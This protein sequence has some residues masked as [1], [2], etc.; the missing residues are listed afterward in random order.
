MSGVDKVQTNK[1]SINKETILRITLHLIEEKGG[2]KNVTLR[3]IAKKIECAHTNLY[4]YF[5]SLDELFWESLGEVLIIMMNYTDLGLKSN[6]NPEENIYLLLS[7]LIDFSMDHPGW[8]RLI[9][10][11][12]IGGTPSIEVI[13]ILHKPGEEFCAELIKAGNNISKEKANSISDILHCYLHGELCKWINKR[14]FI[15]SREEIKIKILS[16]LKYMY[17]SLIK[18]EFKI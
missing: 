6:T 7:N 15:D 11:D 4:N 13:K 8:Y 3:D 14:S 17:R 16:N 9:W 10:L 18:E 1:N 2:I 12:S 5:T